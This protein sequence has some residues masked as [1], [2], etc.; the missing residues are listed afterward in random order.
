MIYPYA[1][2]KVEGR[3]KLEH[4]LV[5]EAYLGRPLLTTEIVHHINHDKLDNRIGNLQLINAKDHAFHHNKKHPYT[6]ICVIC[7]AVFTPHPTK[8]GRKRTCSKECRYKLIA[9]AWVP[10]RPKLPPKLT[11]NGA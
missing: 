3:K 4:R 10:K 5:M 6:K 7:S 11:Q 2:R 1:Q 8:R 9:L